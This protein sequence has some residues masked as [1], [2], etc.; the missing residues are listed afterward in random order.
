LLA[1]LFWHRPRPGVEQLEYE[2]AQ[3][4]FHALLEVA[5][6]CFRLERLPFDERPGYED[7]YLVEN[8]QELGELNTAA[9]DARR[10]AGH[11][12]AAAMA[13][14]GWGALYASLRGP[15][16]IPDEARWE[17]KP[18][19]ESTA[20]F[21]EGIDAAVAVWQR[22]MVLGPAP[23]LCIAMASGQPAGRRALL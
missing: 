8:W 2:E 3:R 18:R 17:H 11:D 1:Y 20:D 19:G 13:L 14:D 7:W 15:A 9:V 4:Q 23:E 10:K 22:Q 21:L 5:S 6:A 16:R 12:R